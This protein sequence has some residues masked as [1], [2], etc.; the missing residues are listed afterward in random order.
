MKLDLR[1]RCLLRLVVR[2]LPDPARG[3][4]APSR[5]RRG[6]RLGWPVHRAR[7]VPIREF[8]YVQG[9][10]AKI[11]ELTG[12]EFGAG[13][14]R[15]IADGSFVMDSEAAARGAGRAAPGRP[16]RAAVELASGAAA[17]L[18]RRRAEPVR[19]GDLSRGRRGAPAWT[20]T[21]SSPPSTAPAA[22][23]AAKADFARAAGLGVAQLPHPAGRSTANTPTALAVGHASVDEIDRRLARPQPRRP[24]PP[25]LS[26]STLSTHRKESAMSTL[27]FTV[28]DLDFPVGSKNKTATLVTGETRGAAGRR[29]LHPRRRPPAGRRDPRLRQDADHGL[30]QPRRPRLLLRRRGHRRRLPRGRVRRHPAGDRAHPGTPT[31]ASSRPG[32]ASAPTCPPAWS[33]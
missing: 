13:Y 20:R 31:R 30:H 23:A 4:L 16:A 2:L 27:D 15:L 29:R 21:A 14:E 8:G 1:L 9:A 5:P 33:T 22:V 12:A 25:S 3:R 10:N 7:R 11:A 19:P 6:S 26:R 32:R 24:D 18:L 17:R 28:I